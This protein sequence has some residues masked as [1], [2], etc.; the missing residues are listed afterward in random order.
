MFLSLR[1]ESLPEKEGIVVSFTLDKITD[2]ITN[3][4]EG[5]PKSS[6]PI[7]PFPHPLRHSKG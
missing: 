4:L 3:L 1:N 7:H 2:K 6:M 5:H